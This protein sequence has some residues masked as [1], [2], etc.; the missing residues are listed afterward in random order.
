MNYFARYF[1][2]QR[3]ARMAF[4]PDSVVNRY[5]HA[6]DCEKRGDKKLYSNNASNI[7][8][9]GVSD[10]SPE[11]MQVDRKHKISRT[12]GTD[13]VRKCG[14]VAMNTHR[15]R[16]VYGDSENDN[17]ATGESDIPGEF[18]DVLDMVCVRVAH[19]VRSMRDCL[20]AYRLDWEV[21]E[22]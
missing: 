18:E 7:P 3:R 14:R 21:L 15:L 16:M 4:R 5:E 11:V 6:S 19:V 10:R 8:F 20:R 2:L 22:R 17:Q 13:D 12:D 1:L 9:G